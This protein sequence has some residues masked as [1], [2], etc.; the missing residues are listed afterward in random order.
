MRRLGIEISDDAIEEAQLEGE[1]QVI[2][3]LQKQCPIPI[4]L[5]IRPGLAIKNLKYQ[6]LPMLKDLLAATESLKSNTLIAAL[7]GD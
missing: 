3:L 7:A 6:K 4:E 1:A 2:S 5:E